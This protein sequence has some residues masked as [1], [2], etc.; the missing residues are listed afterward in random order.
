M[1]IR[2]QTQE[3]MSVIKRKKNSLDMKRGQASNKSQIGGLT[4][5]KTL[6]NDSTNNLSNLNPNH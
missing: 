6:N 2:S 1:I 4:G 3:E 5:E